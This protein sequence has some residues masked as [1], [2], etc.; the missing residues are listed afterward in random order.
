LVYADES[1]SEKIGCDAGGATARK[2]VKD[3]VTLKGAGKNNTV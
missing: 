3:Y 2:R 1:A